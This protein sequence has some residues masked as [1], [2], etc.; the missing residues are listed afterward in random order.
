MR[1]LL[2]GILAWG[3][4]L[5]V[6]KAECQWKQQPSTG[7]PEYRFP[8]RTKVAGQSGVGPLLTARLLDKED[9]AK[10]HRAIVEV[11]TDGVQLV[12]AGAAQNQPR[13]DEAH[14]QYALD[15][16]PVQNT[17][18]KTCT[19]ENLQPGEHRIHINLASSDN[20]KIGQ[21]TTLN[22]KVP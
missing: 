12:D 14:I 9:N 18:S 1:V 3:I 15:N 5:E 2:L 7:S 21:G 22:V 6:P 16:Q 13:L 19:F 4:L 8:D 17:T 20:R 10:R 11:Q